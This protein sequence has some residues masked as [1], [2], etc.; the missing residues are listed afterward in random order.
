MERPKSMRQ[1]W[2][3]IV[4][5]Y[6]DPPPTSEEELVNLIRAVSASREGIVAEV[7]SRLIKASRELSAAA[8]TLSRIAEDRTIEQADEALGVLRQIAH[9][10]LTS[11]ARRHVVIG[12]GR[13][14]TPG[15][16]AARFREDADPTIREAVAMVLPS[17]FTGSDDTDVSAHALRSLL[18]LARDLDARVRET[19]VFGLGILLVEGLTK[20]PEAQSA[21]VNARTDPDPN[22]RNEAR[23]LLRE[24]SSAGEQSRK[25]DAP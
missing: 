17:V 2:P 15:P 3:R 18:E 11:E 4:E 8:Y 6:D 25:G 12:L 9:D 21:L 22:V 19:A 5:L 7:Q 16:E 24:L 13:A 23:K 20:S 14:H 1:I 10:D